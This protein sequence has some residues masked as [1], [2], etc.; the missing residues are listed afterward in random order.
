MSK[1][2]F[3]L[4]DLLDKLEKQASAIDIKGIYPEDIIRDFAKLDAYKL[5]DDNGEFNFEYVINLQS[6][7]ASICLNTAFCMWCQSACIWYLINSEN[8]YLKEEFLKDIIDGKVLAGTGLSNSMKAFANFEE[9][10]LKAIKT[11]G[12]YIIN[13]SLPFVSNVQK[14]HYFGA[15]IQTDDGYIVGFID[16]NNEAISIQDIDN[17]FA[18]N[19]SATVKTTLK[20][21]FLEEKFLISENGQQFIEKIRP[22]FILLQLGMA[23]GN[24][25]GCI[26]V[27]KKELKRKEY[28]N[29]PIFEDKVSL[30][31]K[32]KEEL[33]FGLD[34]YFA[35]PYTNQVEELK[36]ILKARLDGVLLSQEVSNEALL[37]S[38]G[39][40][41]YFEKSNAFRKLRESY[42]VAV[43]TPS[44]KHL[45]I[46]LATLR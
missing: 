26:D 40:R 16:T 41:G 11:N 8:N 32:K 31:E 22:G 12:G 38:G 3:N 20:N 15:L 45:K 39:S 35:N 10:K 14:G 27:I 23:L 34:K 33:Y 44:I 1:N 25:D 37:C 13:G 36:K 42:F 4:D 18:L 21:Y 17:F 7:V 9:V 28:L 6:R 43:V 24:I 5:V 19:G 2:S 46:L 30:F 29:N